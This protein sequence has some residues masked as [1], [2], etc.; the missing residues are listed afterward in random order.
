M[1]KYTKEQLQAFKAAF[2]IVKS[3]AEEAP[4]HLKYGVCFNTEELLITVSPTFGYGFTY[5]AVDALA[6]DWPHARKSADGTLLAYFVPFVQGYG[7]WQGPNLEMRLDL[8]DYL[9][10]KCDTLITEQE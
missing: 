3:M 2:L 8:L 9:I 10:A 1:T 6:Q 7:F 5:N 4:D